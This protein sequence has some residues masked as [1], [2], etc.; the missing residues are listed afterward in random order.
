[1][2]A[3]ENYTG[4]YLAELLQLHEQYKLGLLISCDELSAVFK[5]L[6]SY[7]PG[8]KGTDEQQLLS[9]F[10]GRGSAQGRVD[11][12]IR[13]F[14][15]AQFS[16]LGGM[17][18]R[19]F[20]ML[21]QGG[22][23]FGLYA[24]MHLLPMDTVNQ[25]VDPVETEETIIQYEYHVKQLQTIALRA[26]LLPPAHYRLSDDAMRELAKVQDHARELAQAAELDEQSSVYG[27]RAGQIAR[28]AGIIHILRVAAGELS[29]DAHI[30]LETTCNARDYV[31][32]IQ[33]Y[34]LAAHARIHSTG[35]DT[36]LV[37][38]I[39]KSCTSRQLTAAQYRSQFLTKS[40]KP[41]YSKSA[42]QATMDRLADAGLLT[43]HPLPPSPRGGGSLHA[44]SAPS[45]DK[46]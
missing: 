3:L 26:S 35:D 13:E 31:A 34:A 28:L 20:D 7:K 43:A 15:Y 30:D 29:H 8:G 17:Q 32:H 16:I 1:M 14:D 24:R 2:M 46:S 41:L 4:E 37:Q 38:S 39:I 45:G 21:A 40:K 36:W 9:L 44:F 6:N 19:V 22:D 10:D 25:Y 11:A 12:G 23:P 27:K 33:Q 18:P 5:S 42:I